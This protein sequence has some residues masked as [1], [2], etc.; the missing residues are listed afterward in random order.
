M[1]IKYDTKD[2]YTLYKIF[3]KYKMLKAFYYILQ[4]Y[5]QLSKST[6]YNKFI[7]KK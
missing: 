5:L 2:I 4:T 7:I 6:F 1:K 3:K